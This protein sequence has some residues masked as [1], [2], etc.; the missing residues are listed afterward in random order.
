MSEPDH[1]LETRR[2]LKFSCEDLHPARII[3]K[4]QRLPIA[5]Y[6]GWCNRPLKN[7]SKAFLS[8]CK[9][10]S[11]A[12]TIWM[13][14]GILSP[15]IG[16]QRQNSPLGCFDGRAVEARYPGE[17]Q[18]ANESDTRFAMNQVNAIL[19]ATKTVFAI[20]GLSLQ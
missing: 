3:I 10:I 16:P 18:E 15:M 11:I 6:V 19:D 4:S 13:L 9:S 5:M 17:W 7:P 8:S 14:Y 1:I 2:W 20:H 12:S